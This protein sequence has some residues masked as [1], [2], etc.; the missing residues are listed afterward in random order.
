MRPLIHF[1]HANGIPSASYASFFEVLGQT[2]DILSIAAIGTDPRYPVTQHWGALVDQLLDSVRQQANGR[3]VVGIGHSL[4]GALTL[5]AARQQ[6]QY[7]SQ[8]IMLDP[9]LIMG[10]PALALHVSKWLPTRWADRFSP[11][12]LSHK[13]REHWPDRTTAAASL[14]HR[15]VFRYFN[16]QDFAAYIARG[17]C[18]DPVR[19][20][21]TLTIPRA[22]EVAIFRT[23]PSWGWLPQQRI[24]VP[25]HLIVGQDS[26]FMRYRLPHRIKRT[27]GIDFQCVP[28]G[29][30]FPFEYPERTAQSI[31]AYL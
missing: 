4:G 9:P 20:G 3:P 8:V 17:L 12:G 28:G 30:M 23:N 16:D 10:W 13:R 11:A 27:L 25:S 7:F 22:T 1:A 31:L 21:V 6:P 5:M 15:G 29:H 14:R 26:E 18:D 24:P 19:G 2:V